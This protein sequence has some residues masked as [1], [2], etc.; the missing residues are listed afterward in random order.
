LSIKPPEGDPMSAASPRANHQIVGRRQV[1]HTAQKVAQTTV[2]K[3]VEKTNWSPLKIALISSSVAF[4]IAIAISLVIFLLLSLG[5]KES[6]IDIASAPTITTAVQPFESVEPVQ[7]PAAQPAQAPLPPIHSTS[8]L[9][10][11]TGQESEKKE[12]M[13]TKVVIIDNSA[14]EVAKFKAQR[15]DELAEKT[16]LAEEAEVK[17]KSDEK[18]ARRLAE[19]KAR[20]E[21]L[22][23][24]AETEKV[25][26]PPKI[27]RAEGVVNL[28]RERNEKAKRQRVSSQRRK[29]NE[30]ELQ[31]AEDNLQ[32]LKNALVTAEK[33]SE[34]AKKGLGQIEAQRTNT[35]NEQ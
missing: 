2:A 30:V 15:E 28:L 12:E 20:L 6:T 11:T 8:Q 23:R 18:E 14:L 21:N 26:L 24:G 35:N 9:A 32:S 25:E 22:R 13:T 33:Q 4:S 16:R 27:A 1:A 5:K 7:N 29:L 19:L 17:R 31:K 10:V 3:A 34:D